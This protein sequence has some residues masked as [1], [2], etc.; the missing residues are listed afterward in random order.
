MSSTK[1]ALFIAIGMGMALLVGLVLLEIIF[2]QWFRQDPWAATR[3]LNIIR[4]QSV[5]YNVQNIQ[6]HSSPTVA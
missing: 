6:G 4:Q 3:Q 2:G 1:K 5:T